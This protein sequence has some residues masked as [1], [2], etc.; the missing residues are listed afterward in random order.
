MRASTLSGIGL[1]LKA[2]RTPSAA[3]VPSGD[4]PCPSPMK[5]ARRATKRAGGIQNQ[6]LPLLWSAADD[7]IIHVACSFVACIM[8]KAFLVV[9]DL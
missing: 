1:K 6:Y 7:S 5:T 9:R 2:K 8:S 3:G 4:K